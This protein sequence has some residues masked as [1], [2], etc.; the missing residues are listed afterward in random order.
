MG[1]I[2]QSLMP[3][4]RIKFR[5]QLHWVYVLLPLVLTGLALV[6]TG[7]FMVRVIQTVPDASVLQCTAVLLILTFGL[8]GLLRFTRALTDYLTTEFAVTDQR[9]IAK[10]G[11]LRRRTLELP[12]KQIES[13]GVNQGL[14]GR[15]FD[16]GT[17]VVVG[18]GGT[19]EV[20][21]AI[22]APFSFRKQI[23]LEIQAHTQEGRQGSASPLA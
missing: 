11:W 15:I 13:L 18:T 3:H 23:M 8:T 12:L 2:E 6:I 21:P 1:Y 14:G 20:F 9:I 22:R 7:Y 4:E 10:K 16:Y 5:A 19:R 17:L